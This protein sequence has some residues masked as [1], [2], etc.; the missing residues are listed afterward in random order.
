MSQ[1]ALLRSIVDMQDPLN[2]RS[3]LLE[4]LHQVTLNL[5]NRHDV[6]DIL[7]SLLASIGDLLD[8]P[9]VSIDLLEGDDVI[10]TY[11]ATPG[12]PLVTGDRMKR[13]EGGHLSWQAIDTRQPA[14]LD[15]YST[16]GNRRP[17]YEGFYIR[18]ILLMPIVR[19]GKAIGT[20]NFL[21][22]ETGKVFRDAEIEVASR[23][24]ETVALVL[25]NAQTY[26]QLQAELM[27]RKRAEA[28]LR[29]SQTQLLEKEHILA[30]LDERDR[31]ARDLHDGIGQV[32]GYIGMQ[33]DTA[34]NLLEQGNIIETTA[35][36]DRLADA[37]QDANR[38]L[39]HYISTLK[40]ENARVAHQDFFTALSD[41]CQNLKQAYDFH[42]QLNLPADPPNVLASAAVETQLT[43]IIR[44]AL[45][46]ARKHAGV[47]GASV[48]LEIEGV[49]LQ[50]IVEDK[51]KGMG[52]TYNGPER[53]RG[54]HFG[55]GIMSSRAEEVGG[56]L[57]I[58][59]SSGGTRIIARLPRKLAR[60][61]L[62]QTR[63]LLADDHPLFQ[64]GLQNMLTRQGVPVVGVAKDGQEAVE[65][66]HSLGPDML[67][68]DIH[69]PRLN[70]LE[71]TRRL[72]T[73][74]PDLKIVILT[75][76]TQEADLFEALRAGAAGY[77]LK[78]MGSEELLTLLG[79]IALGE[80][81]ISAEMAAKVLALFERPDIQ[82]S[83]TQPKAALEA[84]SERQLDVLRLV[85]QGLSYKQAGQRLYLT[86][87]TIKFHMGEILKRLQ[88]Q[89]RRDLIAFARRQGVN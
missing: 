49:Y 20:L 68:I 64:I 61:A 30:T 48:S 58:E 54:T 52:G 50:A 60:E 11:A 1:P 45:N 62:S 19:R 22:F 42:V 38:D 7:D 87:R 18:A 74:L 24:A 86:E 72:K 26:A 75:S 77:L 76:S 73:E 3:R 88:L 56:E 84:L 41:Y 63:I 71:A 47:S 36:L 53:R 37:A 44:E 27:E 13:G 17:L 59:T 85:A 69:M 65:L 80:A 79:E 32:L 2:Y 9:I 57:M 14:V 39:R 10:V 82:P 4:A 51:G 40:D 43:Y 8:S 21:R 6:Q 28:E 12:Q 83:P 16:W 81:T 35:I 29:D 23:L 66:A 5:I 46:N 89:N 25:D 55:L 33:S 34:R 70:G 67:L 31:L 15:D 78:G